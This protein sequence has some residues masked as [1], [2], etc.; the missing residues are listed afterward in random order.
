MSPDEILNAADH[1]S[2]MDDR[3][4][5]VALLIVGLL[6]IG[7]LTK[8]FMA[9]I[10]EL[11]VEVTKVREDFS[12]HLKKQTAEVAATL[13]V[14]NAVVSQNSEVLSDLRNILLIHREK[15]YSTTPL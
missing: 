1:A 13:A 2:R 12:E 8:Y 4:L 6:S 3:W 7:F 5:F 11:Q 9:E 10:G 15:S 14:S